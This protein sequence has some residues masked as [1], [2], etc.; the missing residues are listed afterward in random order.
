ME[1]TSG[2]DNKPQNH[3]KEPLPLRNTDPAPTMKQT[4]E[5]A[6]QAPVLQGNVACKP[7]EKAPDDWERKKFGEFERLSLRWAR[8][9]AVFVGLTLVA[10]TGTAV[11]FWDQ[12]KEMAAQTDQLTI[13][14]RQARRD[15]AEG[16]IATAKQLAAAQQ[17][18]KAA[19]D[20]VG[21]IKRQMRQDQRPWVVVKLDRFGAQIGQ[22]P[23]V[24]LLT[25]NTGKTAA[26]FVL[27]FIYVEVVKNG[28]SPNLIKKPPDN[29]PA[30]RSHTR[31]F[32][33]ILLPQ[34]TPIKQVAIRGDNTT[35]QPALL[36]KTEMD[37]LVQGNSYLAAHGFVNYWDV[38]NVR[39][40]TTFCFWSGELDPDKSKIF[41]AGGCTAYNDVDSN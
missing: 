33:G 15:S 40:W 21:A 31:M 24:I 18:T 34:E 35:N 11:V 22:S 39:H 16:S 28:N 17:Q 9:N 27:E 36:T 29:A 1:T 4:L 3:E 20:S 26:K 2:E 12:F 14:A 30:G 23:S 8:A 41:S 6:P 13:S 38:F 19:Q 5:S 37:D 7:S 10:I 25:S 32:T